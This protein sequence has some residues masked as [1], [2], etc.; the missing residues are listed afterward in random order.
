MAHYDFRIIDLIEFW[1]AL[2]KTYPRAISE[3]IKYL[4]PLATIF[5][6]FSAMDT[7][8]TKSKN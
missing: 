4:I 8:K 2:T 6:E 1:C 5:F 7:I 3:A